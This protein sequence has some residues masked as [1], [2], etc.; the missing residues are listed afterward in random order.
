MAVR[1]SDV[2]LCTRLCMALC[3]P[4][5]L[6]IMSYVVAAG[7]RLF[8]VLAGR[9][10][11]ESGQRPASGQAA[12]AGLIYH[13]AWPCGCTMKCDTNHIKC[14]P[15]LSVLPC[16]LQSD[17]TRLALCARQRARHDRDGPPGTSPADRPDKSRQAPALIL[18]GA[19]LGPGKPRVYADRSQ[20]ARQV[21]DDDSIASERARQTAQGAA[22]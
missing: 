6:W 8:G 21:A 1:G 7:R 18:Q 3:W 22:R 11:G 16:L 20:T 12:R 4:L 5:S 17:A 9:G 13:C 19:S 14:L 15:C 10:T 2:T